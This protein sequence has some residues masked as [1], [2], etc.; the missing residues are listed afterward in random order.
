MDDSESTAKTRR[1]AVLKE[2]GLLA[3]VGFVVFVLVRLAFGVTQSS[4]LAAL[5][6]FVSGC[7][8]WRNALAA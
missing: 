4:P 6:I 5:I 7:H 3:V 1:Q 2:F 8:K